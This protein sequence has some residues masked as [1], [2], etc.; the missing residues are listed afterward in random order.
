MANSRYTYNGTDVGW[1]E[2]FGGLAELRG[3]ELGV[4]CIDKLVSKI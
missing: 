2:E 3:T 1:V 4:V